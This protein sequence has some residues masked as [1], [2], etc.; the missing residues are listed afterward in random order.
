MNS[1][2]N[3]K[4]V[5]TGSVKVVQ[6]NGNSR[7]A[8]LDKLVSL[9]MESFDSI[10]AIGARVGKYDLSSNPLKSSKESLSNDLT[11]LIANMGN[12]LKDADSKL[13]PPGKPDEDIDN[14]T[15]TSESLAES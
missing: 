6:I 9:V 10:T 7:N 15:P 3:L 2:E 13:I 12:V 4:K 1:F 8:K 14:E 11:T 5:V